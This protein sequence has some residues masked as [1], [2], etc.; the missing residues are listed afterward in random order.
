MQTLEMVRAPVT[1][2][3]ILAR[4]AKVPRVSLALIPTP[5]HEAPRLAEA[6]GVGRLFIKRDDLTGLAFGGNKTRNLEFRMAD[7]VAKGADVFIAGLETQSNSARQVTAACNVLGMKPV[8]VLRHD[9]DWD[10][11]GNLLIDRVLGADIRWVHAAQT[12]KAAMDATLIAVAEEQRALGRNPYVMNHNPAFAMGS[13]FGYL[14]CL[15]EIVEQARDLG[16]A[17]TDLYMCSGNKGHAGLVLGKALLGERFRVVAISQHYA[18]DRAS[19]ALQGA[20]DAAEALGWEVPLSEADVESYDDY[21][22]TSYG[23]PS[24][25]GMAALLLTARTEGLL[26]DPIYSAKAMAGLIDHVRQG[27]VGRESTVVFIHTG[28]QPALFAFKDE[29]LEA[30]RREIGRGEKASR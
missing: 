20:R 11:Q 1:A 12:D 15:L 10:G 2:E 9:R 14:L 23:E 6:I 16:I 5:L 21:V 19:G 29:L 3:E 13:A 28:G 25:A 7:A 18:D 24:P 26:L 17:P 30:L 27:K 8:L 22:E 4:V